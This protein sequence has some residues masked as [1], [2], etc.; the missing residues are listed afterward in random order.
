MNSV[1]YDPRSPYSDTPQLSQYVDYLDVWSPRV[2]LP[3]PTDMMISIDTR[4]IGRPDLL[5]YDLYGTPG[6][7]WVFASRNPD[8]IKDPIYDL[9][10]N[11]VIYAPLRD[12]LGAIAR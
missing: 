8:Q 11:L 5:S 3:D 1:T 2:V 12:R 9:K 10:A 6:L 4:Y 7:W